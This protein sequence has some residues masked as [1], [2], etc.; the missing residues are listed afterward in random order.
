MLLT[1]VL[2]F[3]EDRSHWGP[4]L[5]GAARCP[6][7]YLVVE[8]Y[9]VKNGKAL[10]YTNEELEEALAVFTVVRRNVR[11]D[12]QNFVLSARRPKRL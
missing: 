6:R 3:L 4:P 2:M 1:H 8:I 12:M 11:P 5:Q 10:K 7:G 9:H